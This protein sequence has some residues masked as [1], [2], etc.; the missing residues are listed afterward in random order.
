M[1]KVQKCYTSYLLISIGYCYKIYRTIICVTLETANSE[2]YM[3]T[4]ETKPISRLNVIKNVGKYKS[5]KK[6]FVNAMFFQT[7]RCI[8][9]F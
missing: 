5:K 3:K 9:K 1:N 2:Y 6:S 7:D 8:R 4:L